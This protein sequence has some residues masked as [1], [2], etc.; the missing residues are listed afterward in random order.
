M[1]KKELFKW[2]PILLP[3]RPRDQCGRADAAAETHRDALLA[4]PRSPPPLHGPPDL[5]VRLPS[6]M[7][8][9][10]CWNCDCFSL[11]LSPRLF[12]DY[13]LEEQ[14]YGYEGALYLDSVAFNRFV[15]ALTSKSAHWLF[16][17]SEASFLSADQIMFRLQLIWNGVPTFSSRSDYSQYTVCLPNEDQKDVALLHSHAPPAGQTLRCTAR[18]PA[19]RQH[20]VGWADCGRRRPLP[21]L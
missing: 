10:S 4:H 1:E 19:G 12:R 17:P 9:T 6:L 20:P 21:P 13:V 15:S 8:F 18:Y 2:T 11:T 3:H 7:W 5:Q 14:R 16:M